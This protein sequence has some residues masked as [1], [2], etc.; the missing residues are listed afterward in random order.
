MPREDPQK[1]EER[2]ARIRAILETETIEQRIIRTLLSPDLKRRGGFSLT[3]D[4]TEI[5]N[6]GLPER[7]KWKPASVGRKLRKMRFAKHHSCNG[8]GFRFRRKRVELL[9]KHYGVSI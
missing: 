8:N 6:K 7:L 4:I 9:A 3:R 1:R 2:K 5:F